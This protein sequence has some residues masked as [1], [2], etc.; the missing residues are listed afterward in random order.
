MTTSMPR[1]ARAS[2]TLYRRSR[3]RFIAPTVV[4][5]TATGPTPASTRRM[6]LMPMAALASSPVERPAKNPVGRRS[7][8]SHTAGCRVASIRPS[9]RSTVR[10]CVSMNAAHTRPVTATASAAWTMSPV[11]ASGTYV[12][13][14]CPVAMGTRAPRPTVTRLLRTRLRRSPKEPLRLKRSSRVRPVPRSGRGR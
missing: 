3:T 9:T 4:A 12:P 14:T 11:S 6:A 2:G 10:F 5:W 1:A 13:S 7:R 8:R